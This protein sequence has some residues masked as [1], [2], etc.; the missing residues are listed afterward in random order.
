MTDMSVNIAGVEFRNPVIAASGTFGET[1]LPLVDLSQFGGAVLKG[2]R[3]DYNP[4]NPPP[5]INE[6]YSGIINSVG[7]QGVGAEDFVKDVRPKFSGTPI[8]ANVWG[9]TIEEYAEVTKILGDSCDMLEIN[10]SCPNVHNGGKVFGSSAEILTETVEAVKKQ[11]KVPI[12]IKLSPNISDLP[13]LAKACENAGADAISLINTILS[14]DIDINT[15]KPFFAKKVAGLSGQAVFP[16]ALRMVWEVANSVNIP[17][18]GLGGIAN[19]ADAIKMLSVGA[20]AVQVGTQGM[21]EPMAIP[22]IAK[23]M[24]GIATAKGFSKI[25]DITGIANG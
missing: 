2:V 17:V 7:F 3:L 16:I 9:H 18:I 8:I 21:I 25:S 13:T 22:R 4:G 10:V 1:S 12:I 23:E 24:Q 14:M 15:L 20:T 6:A 11:A 5:R 19:G